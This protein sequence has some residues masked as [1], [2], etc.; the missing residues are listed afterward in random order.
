MDDTQPLGRSCRHFLAREA[1]IGDGK[2]CKIGHPIRKIVIAA[3]GGSNFGIAYKFPCRPGPQK[4]ADC[5]DYDTKT[6]AE[7]E[8]SKAEV[9]EQMDR[10]VKA[11]PALNNLRAT[12]IKGQVAST[13]V[14]CPLCGSERSAHVTCAIK[15][16][17]HMAMRCKECGEGFIE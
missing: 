4:V 12:M 13:I 3:N 15:V 2:C 11:L 10:L 17:N 8:A 1:V 16:N 6:D 5:P 14:D 7:I 9:L